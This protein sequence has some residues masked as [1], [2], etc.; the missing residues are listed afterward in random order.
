MKLVESAL[1]RAADFSRARPGNVA[2]LT[3]LTMPVVVAFAAVTIDQA[4]LNAQRRQAQSVTDLAALSAAANLANAEQAAASTFS[5]N[6][7]AA[8][9]VSP[10]QTVLDPQ[11][12]LTG[13]AIVVTSGRY[14]PQKQLPPAQRFDNTPPPHNAV[15]VNLRTPGTRFFFADLFPQA[16]IQTTAIASVTA[17]AA[18]SVGSRLASLNG[19][20]VNAVLGALLG[21]NVSLQAMDY[22]GLLAAD[23]DL[24]RF[25]DALAT[26]ANISAATYSDV[27]S[28]SVTVGQLASAMA[29][30]DGLDRSAKLSLEALARGA[31][32]SVRVPL[33]HLF[34]L[35]SL[36]DVALGQ[37]APGLTAMASVLDVLTAAA[38]IADGT[39]QVSVDLGVT[40]PGLAGARAEIAIGEPP[41]GYTWFVVGEKGDVVRTAQTRVLLTVDVL[42]SGAL[43]SVVRLPIYVEVAFAEAKL[44]SVTCPTG[45]PDSV[46]A[47]VSAR[48]GIAALRIGEPSATALADFR[49]GPTFKPAK[50]VNLA[51]VSI[52][53][54]AH[55]E[56]AEMSWQNLTFTATDIR[57]RAVK[58]ISTR[59]LTQSLTT[60]LLQNL[61]LDVKV[62]GLGLGVGALT[63]TL[64]G[65]LGAVTPSVDALL[66]SVLSALGVKVGE[67][68]IRVTGATCGRVVLVQ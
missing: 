55:V 16:E 40:L 66:A 56:I 41:Q 12:P 27:L 58:S 48:P 49:Y 21:S 38:A 37:S 34:D 10:V 65:T 30:V 26:R 1:R 3:A 68:D 15:R 42:G 57:D 63:S 33:S 61:K 28:S 19:G 8:A 20:V 6:D 7:M 4:S 64:S 46:R 17:E 54:A 60:S 18:F 59:T 50:L 35:G 2:T 67:A 39:R 52:E 29:A 25:L 45:R 43:G 11:A 44:A 5:D 36:G 23:I 32:G 62:L 13:P 22:R 47:V 9:I 31:T 51:L 53:G 14:T 24:L